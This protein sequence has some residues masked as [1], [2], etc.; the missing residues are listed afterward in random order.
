MILEISKDSSTLTSQVLR[1]IL[2]KCA[3][4]LLL[5]MLLEFRSFSLI[6]PTS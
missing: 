1:S 5:S 4:M 3:L 6:P 2:T